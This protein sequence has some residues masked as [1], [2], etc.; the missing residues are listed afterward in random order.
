LSSG[1]GGGAGGGRRVGGG[2]KAGGTADIK[3]SN[4]HLTPHTS[5]LR[6][7]NIKQPNNIKKKLNLDKKQQIYG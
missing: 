7:K 1:G 3:S 6:K 4:P 5:Q 2:R